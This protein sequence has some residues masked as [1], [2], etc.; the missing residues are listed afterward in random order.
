VSPTEGTRLGRY[1]I[2]S[3]IGMGG[4]GEV[5]LADDTTLKRPV[6]IKVLAGDYTQNE[7]R[8]QRFEREA[9]AAS[10]LNHPHIVTIYE[11]GSEAGCHFIATEYVEGDSLRQHL[12]LVEMDLRELVDI[13][14]QIASALTAAH[15]AGI[16]HR[17]IKPENIMV[18]RDGYVKV[19]DFG[20]AKLAFEVEASTDTEAS[21]QMFLKT[22]PGRIMGTTN[23]MSPEQARGQAVDA[24][25][26]IFSLGVVL[27]EMVTGQRPFAGNTKSDVL[28]A[29]LMVEPQPLA[30][31]CPEVPAELNRIVSKAL[32]K[33]R[34][35]RYQSIK[36]LLLD[37][38]SLRHELEFAAKAGR[39]IL[40]VP[41]FRRRRTTSN[42][43][44]HQAST[45][46][47]AEGGPT[48]SELF[49]NEV[50]SHPKRATVTLSIIFI[51]VAI[52]GVGLYRLIRLAQRPESF[53]SMRMA[54]A[55]TAGNV[56]E[57]QVAISPDGKYVVYVMQETGQQSLWVR[58]VG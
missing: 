46:R 21:T 23:Y 47:Q 28:A 26:D 49:I 51:L 20:L 45:A 41:A 42:G 3:Q 52:G 10:S 36:E 15:Q 37:L 58:Q 19:L 40:R 29:V 35:E 13:A 16:V 57:G 50:K 32:K 34:E 39:P 33:D 4:M 31:K 43:S 27:Y 22:E 24:R 14:I 9:C 38:K 55:T 54:K 25:T 53:Q 56:L 1:Q 44:A 11:I 12:I 2:R 48:I 7:E 18:R 17:D 30:D 8:L 6:A 5:Y